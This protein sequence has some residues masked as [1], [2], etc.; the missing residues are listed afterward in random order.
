MSVFFGFRAKGP[1]RTFKNIEKSPKGPTFAQ[2]AK[3][4]GGVRDQESEVSEE[5]TRVPLALTQEPSFRQIVPKSVRRVISYQRTYLR[6]GQSI[7]A[8]FRMLS[9]VIFGRAEVLS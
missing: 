5:S 2:G 7:I 3:Q 8:I 6:L 1:K 4:I 9:E